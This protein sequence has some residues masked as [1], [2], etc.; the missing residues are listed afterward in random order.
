VTAESLQ[1][2]GFIHCSTAEQ[3]EATANRIFRGSGE[4]LLLEVDPARLTAPLKYERATDVGDE[5]PHIYGL[6]NLDAVTRTIALPEGPEGYVLP[7][8]L[9]SS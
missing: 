9:R 8:E 4:L 5:F 7:P 2:E 1:A 3:V 6:L